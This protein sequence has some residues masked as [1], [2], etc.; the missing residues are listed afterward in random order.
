M[1]NI[2]FCLSARLLH[3]IVHSAKQMFVLCTVLFSLFA[4]I[5]VLCTIVLIV[6]SR[7]RSD[8]DECYEG[9]HS[10]PSSEA[11]RNTI[12]GFTCV[13]AAGFDFVNG[14]CRPWGTDPK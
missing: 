1:H 5:F 7:C 12:G 2:V 11:C 10:C 6:L 9:K 4:Q 8:I 13:C 14:T 3:Y